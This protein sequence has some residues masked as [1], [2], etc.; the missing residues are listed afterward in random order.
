MEHAGELA[1]FEKIVARAL[2]QGATI[3]HGGGRPQGLPPELTE[4]FFVEPTIMTD[5]TVDMDVFNGEIFG[6]LAPIMKI[7]SLDEAIELANR[8]QF[9]LGST[10]YTTESNEIHRATNEIVAGMVWVNA[11]ILDNDAGPFGGRKMSGLGRQLGAEGLET[12]RHT[13]L[14]MVD[15]IASEHDFWW[16]PYSEKESWQPPRR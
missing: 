13:K 11:P 1:R 5:V 2:E 3:R 4:G 12:F 14:V 9:G 15:P 6:P 10:I 16:F 7:S 8:S